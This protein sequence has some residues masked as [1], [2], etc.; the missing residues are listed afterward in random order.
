MFPPGPQGPARYISN[1]KCRYGAPAEASRPA[2]A[3]LGYDPPVDRPVF[4]GFA[5]VRARV[6]RTFALSLRA[7]PGSLQAPAET[8]YL[9]ARAGDTVADRSWVPD[10]ERAALL[11]SL[12]AALAGG[13]IDPR[14]WIRL[15]EYAPPADART[16]AEADLVRWTPAL[17]NRARSLPERERAEVISVVSTLLATME[18]E[19]RRFPSGGA[20]CA[21]PDAAS[22]TA[23]TNGIAGCVGVFWTR[24]IAGRRSW[25]PTA[26]RALESEGRRYG[27]GLQLVNVLRDLPRDL[28]RGRCVLPAD[29]LADVGLQAA[30]LLD[31]SSLPRLRPVLAKW[32][33]RARRGLL[34]G[35]V[36]TARLPFFPIRLR[37]AT[38][39][40]ARLG[41][42][43]LRRLARSD[44]RL[45]PS[46]PIRISRGE[47]RRAIV[48]T[49]CCCLA[50]RGPRCLA[51]PATPATGP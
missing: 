34:A 27:R 3:G 36:Y 33:T 13:P 12:R 32:E 9:L 29:E 41:L 23:Y 19:L 11:A 18:D 15:A 2:S 37:V 1:W 17:V 14:T 25:A 28:R 24:L 50:R 26:V 48:R 35:L 6:S 49:F 5:E 7:L 40:P 21:L 42:L 16:R 39:L 46:A 4:A 51:A 10:Q 31:A 43:T 20:P 45:D 8:A 22:L 47:V 30:D 38:A 44:A